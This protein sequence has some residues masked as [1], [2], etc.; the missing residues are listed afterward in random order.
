MTITTTCTTV[1]SLMCPLFCSS[2]IFPSA[3]VRRHNDMAADRKCLSFIIERNVWDEELCKEPPKQ[4]GWEK[5]FSLWSGDN[6]NVFVEQKV[7]RK[8]AENNFRCCR[9]TSRRRRKKLKTFPC[10]KLVANRGLKQL[11]LKSSTKSSAWIV[12]HGKL[13]FCSSHCAL[14]PRLS[15]KYLSGRTFFSC[16]ARSSFLV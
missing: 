11:A 16:A 9:S 5:N 13:F 14:H 2:L 7:H 15:P 12:S 3:F 4:G 6:F 1:S 8:I 10:L